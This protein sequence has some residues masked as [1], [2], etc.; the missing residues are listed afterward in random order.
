MSI[1][2]HVREG[3]WLSLV[4]G[5]PVTAGKPQLLSGLA[6]HGASLPRDYPLRP[7]DSPQTLTSPQSPLQLTKWFVTSFPWQPSGSGMVGMIDLDFSLA[8]RDSETLSHLPEVT[9]PMDDPARAEGQVC[10]TFKSL[11]SFTNTVG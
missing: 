3:P 4:G 9:Q 11:W 7:K 8:N 5:P 6:V 10:L 1:L 2:N